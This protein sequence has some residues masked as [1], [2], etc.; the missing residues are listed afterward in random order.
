MLWAALATGML[1]ACDAPAERL[2]LPDDPSA[3]EAAMLRDAEAMLAER[4]GDT[5]I[6]QPRP[7]PPRQENSR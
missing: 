2:A 6:L 3:R 1:A 7:S 4:P 5:A